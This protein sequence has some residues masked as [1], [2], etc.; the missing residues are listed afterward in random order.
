[1]QE[2][3]FYN[4]KSIQNSSINFLETFMIKCL[5]DTTSSEKGPLINIKIVFS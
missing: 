1:M 5:L 3:F 4:N 2:T